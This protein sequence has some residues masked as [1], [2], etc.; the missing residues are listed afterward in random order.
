MADQHQPRDRLVVVELADE[1]GHDRRVGVA[2]VDAREVGAV[3]PVLAGA[4][5]EH[6][7]AGLAALGAEGED[8]GLLHRLGIDLGVL[9]DRGQGADAVAQPRG[10]FELHL[11]GRGLHLFAQRGH[12][13]AAL[14]AQ[15]RLGLVDQAAV[16]LQR[17][18]PDAGGGAAADLVQHA[19]PGAALVDAVGA[20]PQQE[21]LLQGVEGAGDRP[22]AGEGAE[23]VALDR[24]GAAVLAQL[25]GGVLAADDDLG[26]RLVV[27]QQHVEARLERLDQVDLEQQG[28]GLGAGGGELHRPGQVDH[29]GDAVGVEPALGVLDHPLLQR[30]RLADIE[31]LPALAEHP[32]DARGVGQ[33]ADLILDQGR[34]DQG[35]GPWER[36]FWERGFGR[37]EVVGH[38][39]EDRGVEVGAHGLG[40]RRLIVRW[41]GP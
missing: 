41:E 33:A 30:P 26:E 2:L 9:G 28:V 21:R 38:R 6:L 12:H 39:G 36:G 16:V 37:G 35:R 15:E 31:R 24:V 8:V 11:V 1:G 32:V 29:Q 40:V 3:A 27:A 4:E 13:R 5:E 20:R 22:G 17:H 7:H 34:A 23:V 18:Q 25:G 10:L 19:R 14:A